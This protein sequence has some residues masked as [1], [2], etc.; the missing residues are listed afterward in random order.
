MAYYRF[1]KKEIERSVSLILV[2][3]DNLGHFRHSLIPP[4]LYQSVTTRGWSKDEYGKVELIVYPDQG[5]CIIFGPLFGFKD[6]IKIRIV[7]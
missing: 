5:F 1:Y 7:D 4:Y 6:L 3:L 2:I